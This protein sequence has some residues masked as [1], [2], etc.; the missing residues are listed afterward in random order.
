MK[1]WFTLF[2]HTKEF[3]V[4]E[5]HVLTT[6]PVLPDQWKVNFKVKATSWYP[7]WYR[8]KSGVI[9]LDSERGKFHAL[10][11]VLGEYE[12]VMISGS[13]SVSRKTI[14][15]YGSKKKW[16]KKLQKGEEWVEIEI[17]QKFNEPF[18]GG[19]NPL[20]HPKK[21]WF[22]VI[23]DGEEEV[24]EENKRP[25][26]TFHDVKLYTGRKTNRVKALKGRIKDLSVKIKEEDLIKFRLTK[27]KKHYS[28][29]PP[30]GQFCAW[31]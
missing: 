26:G 1:G 21:L 2:S 29:E 28:Q 27:I 8:L 31:I 6:F 7:S 30:P 10:K 17:S 16:K 12:G 24:V 5:D 22:R 15:G 14:G 20:F 4:R 23:I 19:Y 13:G 18:R 11:I 25:Q 3:E 9:D